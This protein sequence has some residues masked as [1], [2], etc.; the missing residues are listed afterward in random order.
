MPSLIL[1]RIRTMES[2]TWYH[3]EKRGGGQYIHALG[4]IRH[5]QSTFFLANANKQWDAIAKTKASTRKLRPPCSIDMCKI[6][7]YAKLGTFWN[8]MLTGEHYSV[9]SLTH[10]QKS[11]SC[12]RKT[13]NIW[14]ITYAS[15]LHKSW[16]AKGGEIVD[17]SR[18]GAYE[19][20]KPE[21]D[22]KPLALAVRMCSLQLQ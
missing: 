14:E 13:N 2:Y 15:C 5:K 19:K 4:Q 20:Q 22:S 10:N 11:L 8:N 17:A 21:K 12:V 9:Y 6:Y 1:L 16:C 3:Y 18:T 7:I